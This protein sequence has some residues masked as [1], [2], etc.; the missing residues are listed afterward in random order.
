MSS[1]CLADFLDELGHAGELVRVAAQV[2]P[3]LE[4]TEITRRTAQTGGPALLLSLA[5]GSDTPLV[6]GL[7]GTEQRIC[8]GLGVES[9]DVVARKVADLAGQAR[10]EGWF[11]RLKASPHMVSLNGIGPRRLRCGPCQRVVRLG[12]DVDLGQL[13]VLQSAPQEHGRTITAAAVFTVDPDSG[14]QTTGSFDLQ[15]LGADRLAACWAA[16][17]DPAR[18]LGKYGRQGEKMPVAAVLGGDPALLLATRACLPRDVDA[19]TLAGWFRE[20][21]LEV[22][23]CRSIDL[24]V[25]A[26]AEIVIE[27]YVDPSDPPVEA[28]PL[29]TATGHCQS[30]GLAPVMHVTALT[31]RANPV[32]PAVVPGPP[33][34]EVCVVN[35]ALAR[36]FLPLAKLAIP[37]LLD[38]DLPAFG[39]VRHWATISIEKTHAG[40]AR[41]VAHAAWGMRR[42]MFAKLLVIVDQTVD[43]HDVSHVLS[44]VTT[45]VHPGRDVFF[46]QG[47]PDPMDPATPAGALGHRMAIDATVKLPGEHTGGWPTAAVTSEEIRRLVSE[48]WTE[49]GLGP[50]PEGR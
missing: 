44:A 27:G 8:R 1:R 31:H 50:E 25:P 41:R 3:V 24:M 46:L 26:E 43:V 9:L 21:P 18:L 35:R 5:K 19:C 42:L 49:Y 40:Q 15:L 23:S 20:K 11:D 4:A 10:P 14:L 2:D 28:G 37:E 39:A 29:C 45:N 47:P 12:G 22:V 38:Y 30:P 33:P 34:N 17:D 16:H 36:I 32:Y 48:R 6:T 13:P 7:L